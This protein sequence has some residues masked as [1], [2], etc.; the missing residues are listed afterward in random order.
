MQQGQYMPR[1]G[2][3]YDLPRWMWRGILA[4]CACGLNHRLAD[5][6]LFKQV[7]MIKT[8]RIN[9]GLNLRA[10][11]FNPWRDGSFHPFIE[12]KGRFLDKKGAGFG[13]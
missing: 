11:D 10:T 1:R 4:K 3:V 12:K 13:F 6:N 2:M 7:L 5:S 8:N 9:S